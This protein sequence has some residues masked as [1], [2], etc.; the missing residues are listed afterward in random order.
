M[1]SNTIAADKRVVE[2]LNIGT[3][4][5]KRITWEQF[6]FSIEAPHLIRATN[7]SY[8]LENDEHSYLVG[9]EERDGRAV[10]AKC[11]CPA[12]KYSEDQTCKHRGACAMIAGPVVL[13]AAMTVSSPTCDTEEPNSATLA[14]RLWADGGVISE[15]SCGDGGSLI[16]TERDECECSDLPGEFPCWSCWRSGKQTLQ[17]PS[18]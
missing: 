11:S 7:A 13:Q 1:E 12:D 10:P 5:A 3:K 6:E 9:I 18:R 16:E 8:G 2:E 14:D 4:T 15:G 17:Q